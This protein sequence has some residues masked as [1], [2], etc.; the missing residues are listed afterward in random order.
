MLIEVLRTSQTEHSQHAIPCRVLPGTP[1]A[2]RY[3]AR[4]IREQSKIT[5][6]LTCVISYSSFGRQIMFLHI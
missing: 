3:R 6:Y 1:V 2:P 5:H 4:R